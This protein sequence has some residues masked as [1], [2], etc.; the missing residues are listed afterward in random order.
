M[1]CISQ[2][3]S[4]IPG[5]GML[6]QKFTLLL[7]NDGEEYRFGHIRGRTHGVY[8]ISADR[9]IVLRADITKQ[10]LTLE[11][12]NAFWN[13]KCETTP[14]LHEGV[15]AEVFYKKFIAERK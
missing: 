13:S 5:F 7:C 8:S 15:P 3:V 12:Q 10:M 9:E 11:M 14:D 4:V 2:A 1:S 6:L